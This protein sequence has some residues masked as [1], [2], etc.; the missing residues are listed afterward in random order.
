MYKTGD[1]LKNIEKL[2]IELKQIKYPEKIE[3]DCLTEGNPLF[4]LPILHFSLLSYSKHVAE[5]LLENQYELFSKSDKEFVNKIFKA[6]IELF[7]YKP[8]LNP[9]Q[10]F[11]SGYA[12]AKVIFCLEVIRLVKLEHNKLL[13]KAFSV[14]VKNTNASTLNKNK[15]KLNDSYR[16]NKS[17]NSNISNLPARDDF[18]DYSSNDRVKVVN[19]QKSNLRKEL[20]VSLKNEIDVQ[21][22]SPKFN[23][24]EKIEYNG[25]SGSKKYNFN[26]NFTKNLGVKNGKN[27]CDQL[28]SKINQDEVQIYSNN[29]KHN[30]N[31]LPAS[32]VFD[33]EKDE[34][35]EQPKQS[36]NFSSVIEI[37]NSL[38]SSIRDM[39]IKIDTF[40]NSIE[41]RVSKLEA[42]I[43]LVKNKVHIIESNCSNKTAENKSIQNITNN[44]NKIS[45]S[46]SE[47]YSNS[48]MLNQ[49]SIE[50]NEHIFSFADDQLNV[51]NTLHNQELFNKVEHNHNN[52]KYS[53]LSAPQNR[54]TINQIGT[55]NF[56]STNHN[57]QIPRMQNNSQQSFQNNQVSPQPFMNKISTKILTDIEDTDSIIQKVANRFKE[58]QKLLNEFK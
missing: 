45:M 48:N 28:P 1:L 29:T 27:N 42:E 2:K 58:T 13:K 17:T 24:D 26:Q 8:T 19:H 53:T 54:S 20:D 41:D 18:L 46:I 40:K 51:V 23:D 22:A 44:G 10:F 21:M 38:A 39:T 49:S 33:R 35:Q 37:I 14:S 52:H 57:Q 25:R 56:S 50:N 7:N 30:N 5:Y 11:M 4:F 12:E 55:S 6:M 47:S 15:S 32:D 16:S 36:Q 3:V 34:F 31:I 9:R 43:S